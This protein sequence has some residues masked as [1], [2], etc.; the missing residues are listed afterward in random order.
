MTTKEKAVLADIEDGHS[1]PSKSK[2][3]SSTSRTS[4]RRT[5]TAEIADKVLAMLRK[6]PG[7]SQAELAAALGQPQV[8]IFR[9]VGLLRRQSRLPAALLAP[10]WS[11]GRTSK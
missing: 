6:R 5:K 4:V 10:S 7:Q 8:V 3:S 11:K 2:Y 1:G 9:G